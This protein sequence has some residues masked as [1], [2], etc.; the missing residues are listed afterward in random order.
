MYTYMYIYMY[1]YVAADALVLCLPTV[2]CFAINPQ[3]RKLLE[4]NGFIDV[5]GDVMFWSVGKSR[6]KLSW[7]SLIFYM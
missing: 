7:L 3:L 5:V 2:I 6:H 4:R 1:M